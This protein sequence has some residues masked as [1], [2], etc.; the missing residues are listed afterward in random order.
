MFRT[1]GISGDKGQVYITALDCG[2][3]DFSFFSSFLDP[4]QRHS[5]LGKVDSLITLEFRN[6]PIHNLLVKIITAKVS[7]PIGRLDLEGAFTKLQ[8]R[9]IEGTAAKV[10]D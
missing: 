10:I 7:I 5:I 8:N 3:L 1:R 2:Q 9:D 4:L 6:Q